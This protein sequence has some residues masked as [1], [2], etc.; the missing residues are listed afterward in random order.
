MN[1]ISNTSEERLFKHENDFIFYKPFFNV[2]ETYPN[3]RWGIGIGKYWYFLRVSV[4][5]FFNRYPIYTRYITF[6][7]FFLYQDLAAIEASASP[8]KGVVTGQYLKSNFHSHSHPNPHL[9][10][11]SLALREMCSRIRKN[12]ADVSVAFISPATSGRPRTASTVT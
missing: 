11:H 3:W 4:S 7:F 8:M 1:F 10:I 2:L 12:P 5:V 9:L 6:F